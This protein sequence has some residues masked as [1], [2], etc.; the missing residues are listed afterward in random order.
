MVKF[1]YTEYLKFA[2]ATTTKLQE[3]SVLASEAGNTGTRVE[4]TAE[5]P[6]Q[7]RGNESF[8]SESA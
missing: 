5:F 3:W 6:V 1:N 8:S 2:V 7:A 4:F